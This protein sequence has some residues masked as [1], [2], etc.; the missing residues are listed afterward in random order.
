V[1]IENLYDLIRECRFGIHDTSRTELDP[2]NKL[3]RF[4]PFDEGGRYRSRRLRLGAGWQAEARNVG[5]RHRW[6][7]QE[8]LRP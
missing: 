1:R 5:G 7:S 2:D 8:R 6:Q 3:P 4:N